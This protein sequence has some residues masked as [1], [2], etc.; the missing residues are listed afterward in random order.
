MTDDRFQRLELLVG[1]A[2]LARLGRASVAVFGVGGVGSY[3]VEALVR[4]GVGRLTLVDPD[5]ICSSNINRQLQALETTVG[6]PKVDV[7]A[8]RCRTI[9]P[10]IEVIAEQ[11]AYTRESSAQ[12]L[13]PGYDQV[14]DC[15]D[16]ITAKLHLI[17]SCVNR[18]IAII[19]SMGAANKLDPTLIQV[20][21]I[22]A[23]RK[24]R[25]ARIM[26]R[27][28]RRRRIEKGVPVVYSTEE[29]RSLAEG[30]CC[31][32]GT[33]AEAGDYQW[34]RAPLGSCSYIPP[35]FGLTMA[36]VVINRLRGDER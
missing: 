23:T 26:R 1:S 9:N 4:G 15:I 11:Q 22:S 24:C 21:D 27:E 10:D 6:R 7:L 34:L 20:A 28:L 29:F 18:G 35:L 31:S 17:E 19:S 32:T 16:Q 25:L 30:R 5:L 12:L 14:L 33:A 2:G 36:G 8:E 13:E 3:A